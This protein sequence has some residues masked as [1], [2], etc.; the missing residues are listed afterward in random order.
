LGHLGLNRDGRTETRTEW[1]QLMGCRPSCGSPCSAALS[2]KSITPTVDR[3]Q[4]RD[5]QYLLT[6]GKTFFHEEK[7][8]MRSTVE[9]L[10]GRTLGF[11]CTNADPSGRYSISKEV[12]ADPHL[13]CLLQRTR[14]TGPEDAFL[15]T[16]KMFALCAPHL[17]VGGY[18][19][20]LYHQRERAADFDGAEGGSMARNDCHGPFSRLSCG[21]VGK[22]DGWTDLHENL[23]MDYE[24]DRANRTALIVAERCCEC[25]F[26]RLA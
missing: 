3:P 6:D 1:A 17:E 25:K 12:I 15:A 11:F 21:Y 18:G 24:F 5:L 9:R 19:K 2:L 16:L 20:R 22:S 14:L 23:R 7:R 10:S 4:L 8:D 13:P 26:A